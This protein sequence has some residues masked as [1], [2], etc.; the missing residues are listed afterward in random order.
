MT[1]RRHTRVAVASALALALSCV[2][3]P[4]ELD[5]PAAHVTPELVATYATEVHP[6]LEGS[7]AMLDCHGM[8][9]RPLRL[10]AET[11]LRARDDLRD[12]PITGAEL[13]A[14][15]MSLLAVDPGAAIGETILLRKPLA[16]RA[17]G[18]HHLGEDIWPSRD[19]PAYRCLAAWLAGT[20]SDPAAA[21]ACAEAR[22][23]DAVPPEAP[24]AP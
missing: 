3:D 22:A 21:A 1:L 16:A 14:N 2:D 13:E 19:D 12:T 8:P 9:G 18:Y 4:T 11:G 10:Y 5:T 23:R 20:T 24:P 7:C 17:G 6:I 15:V